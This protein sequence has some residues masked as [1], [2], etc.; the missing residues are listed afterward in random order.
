MKPRCEFMDNPAVKAYRDKFKFCPS[1]GFRRDIAIT[2]QDLDLW[3]TVIR[4]WWYMDTKGKKRKK[5]PLG[6][7]AML[8]D[9]GRLVELKNAIQQKDG[10]VHRAEGFP[11]RNQGRMSE[12][13][14][15][16]LLERENGWTR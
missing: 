4:D 3:K 12:S 5:N 14:V 7:K 11:E 9:Y 2:V 10:R 15:P 13:R 16:V 1:V 8:D 6:I